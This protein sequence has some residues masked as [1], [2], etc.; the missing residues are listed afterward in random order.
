MSRSIDNDKVDDGK[1]LGALSRIPGMKPVL[2]MGTGHKIEE[3]KTKPRGDNAAF[4]SMPGKHEMP[5]KKVSAEIEGSPDQDDEEDTV[6]S[7]K[8]SVQAFRQW[9]PPVQ[10]YAPQETIESR[11]ARHAAQA[12]KES[13]LTI[14]GLPMSQFRAMAG[15]EVLEESAASVTAPPVVA[16]TSRVG[17]SG[18][19]WTSGVAKTN[20]QKGG[21]P[22]LEGTAVQ[23]I[24]PKEGPE[25]EDHVG[26]AKEVTFDDAIAMLKKEGI[27]ISDVWDEFLSERGIS[28]DLFGQMLDEAI[29]GDDAEEVEALLAVEDLFQQYV[30]SEN[31]FLNRIMG[32]KPQTV[33]ADPGAV[34][35]QAKAAI[36]QHGVEKVKAMNNMGLNVNN[37][38]H[39]EIFAQRV[40]RHGDR[41]YNR[42]MAGESTVFGALGAKYLNEGKFVPFK[43]GGKDD[44]KADK[45]DAGKKDGKKPPFM[46]KN[47]K[48][49]E[50]PA[51]KKNLADLKKLKK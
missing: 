3:S 28:P 24:A 43:K 21:L 36:A 34:A 51:G 35:S 8:E 6:K 4:G 40:A 1:L 10:H 15:M 14:A 33:Q 27:E 19:V 23:D 2:S 17:K 41:A 50:K 13:G 12:L 37:P 42:A 29:S 5:P 45:K 47:N 32:R 39:H 9:E 20:K 16:G 7:A 18:E 22:G 38:E 49:E 44:K 26:D 30:V 48:K 11:R 31:G 46:A 25:G